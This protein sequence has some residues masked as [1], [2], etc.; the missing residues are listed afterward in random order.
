MDA[1]KDNDKLIAK[2][3]DEGGIL[4]NKLTHTYD[5]TCFHGITNVDQRKLAKQLKEDEETT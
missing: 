2:Y 1:I 4:K 5:A 3:Q